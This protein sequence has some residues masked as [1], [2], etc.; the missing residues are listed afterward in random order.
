MYRFHIDYKRQTNPFGELINKSWT[1]Q[2]HRIY[3]AEY[4]YSLFYNQLFQISTE[5]SSTQ[6]PSH[7]HLFKDTV[8]TIAVKGV[9]EEF[10]KNAW[11]QYFPPECEWIHLDTDRDAT[12]DICIIKPTE[13]F[14]SQIQSVVDTYSHLTPGGILLVENVFSKKTINDYIVALAPHLHNFQDYYFA[15]L[16]HQI[17]EYMEKGELDTHVLV[18]IKKGPRFAVPEPKLTIITPSCRPANLLKIKE[19]VPMEWV[20]EWII[21]YDGKRVTTNPEQFK[22]VPNIKEYLYEG[23]GISG[24]PQRNFALDIIA[25]KKT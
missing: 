9:C 14:E 16:N 2:S 22:D 10:V 5:R 4:V 11:L 17:F 13:T 6:K 8:K 18:L 24:N 12:A 3:A 25:K 1:N 23:E 19:S 15:A 20:K 7:I 21:V